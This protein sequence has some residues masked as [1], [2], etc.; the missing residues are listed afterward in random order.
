MRFGGAITSLLEESFRHLDEFA[1]IG[2]GPD[3]SS[4][5]SDRDLLV[6][7]MTPSRVGIP[8]EKIDLAIEVFNSVQEILSDDKIRFCTFFQ[9]NTQQLIFELAKT[10]MAAGDHLEMVHALFYFDL[11]SMKRVENA[12][13]VGSL[14]LNGEWLAGGLG[15][16][17]V[18]STFL[19]PDFTPKSEFDYLELFLNDSYVM[20]QTNRTLGNEVLLR[21]C[22]QLLKRIAHSV[23]VIEGRRDGRP[24][25]TTWKMVV[26]QRHRFSRTLDRLIGELVE[27]RHLSNFDDSRF[28]DLHLSIWELLR[29]RLI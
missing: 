27:L 17:D 19:G 5:S 25:V 3:P 13:I 8:F 15:Y 11:D 1:V 9:F 16:R 26:E 20:W 10:K 23:A 2:Y 29:T 22:L 6:V 28:L 7:S 12:A 4:D 14:A 24:I 21:Y 18:L